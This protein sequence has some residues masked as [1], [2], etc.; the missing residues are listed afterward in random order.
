MKFLYCILFIFF[1]FK[2]FAD[3][4]EI[5]INGIEKMEILI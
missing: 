5:E 2:S 4:L 3:T 1:S